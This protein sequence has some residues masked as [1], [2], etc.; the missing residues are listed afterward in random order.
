MVRILYTYRLGNDSE[1]WVEYGRGKITAKFNSLIRLTVTLSDTYDVLRT[2]NLT[3]FHYVKIQK[4]AVR[5]RREYKFGKSSIRFATQGHSRVRER[6][7]F[8]ML[9]FCTCARW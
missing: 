8:G 6:K 4:E 9:I 3:A 7:S 1:V 2:A 5:Y